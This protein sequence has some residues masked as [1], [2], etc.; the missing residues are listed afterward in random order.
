M[1]KVQ[2]KKKGGRRC[3]AQWYLLA[4]DI[5]HEKRLRRV[6]YFC[7][8]HG[9]PLQRSVFLFK[10]DAAGLEEMVDGVRARVSDKEDDVRLYP[11]THPGSIW[12]AGQQSDKLQGLY[13]GSA[14]QQSQSRVGKFFRNL[15]GGKKGV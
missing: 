8:K 5:R 4:Y 7:K 14:P 6:H 11:V 10:A 12:A 15:F 9:I 3:R 1:D 2:R 13:G